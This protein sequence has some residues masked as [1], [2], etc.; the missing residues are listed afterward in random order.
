MITWKEL[1]TKLDYHVF[2]FGTKHFLNVAEVGWSEV[3]RASLG[4]K[5]AKTVLP[6]FCL[7]SCGKDLG[8]YQSSFESKEQIGLHSQTNC[9]QNTN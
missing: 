1:K 9:H 4:C 3:Y 5:I 8:I 6:W 2:L 7:A